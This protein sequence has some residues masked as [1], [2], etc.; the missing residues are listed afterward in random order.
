MGAA[1]RGVP[2]RN[3]PDTAD[4]GTSPGHCIPMTAGLLTA[5]TGNLPVGSKT[6][7]RIT[8]PAVTTTT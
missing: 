6:T 8:V 3:Y 5:G 4:T 2:I 7:T 1:A